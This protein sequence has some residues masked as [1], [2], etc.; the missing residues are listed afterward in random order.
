MKVFNIIWILKKKVSKGDHEYSLSETV[1]NG[2]A[3]PV[4]EFIF[5]ENIKKIVSI[6]DFVCVFFN[7]QYMSGV[8]KDACC[9]HFFFSLNGNY[10]VGN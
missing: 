9:I 2:H 7:S 5:T 1:E 6:S 10:A 8:F 4:Y 3:V